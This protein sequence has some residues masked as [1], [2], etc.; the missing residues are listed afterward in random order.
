[1]SNSCFRWNSNIYN[2]YDYP[3]CEELEHFDAESD[4]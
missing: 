4:G 2:N 3:F 1:M